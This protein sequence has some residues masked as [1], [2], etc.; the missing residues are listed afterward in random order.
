MP[1]CPVCGGD[2]FST[3]VSSAKL[4]EECRFRERFVRERLNRP[5]NPEELKDL[6]EF[7]H[8]GRAEILACG[9]CGLLVRR[10]HEPPPAQTY[11][12][13]E[14][15]PA[16]MERL[17]PQYLQAFR[18]KE[19]PFRSLLPPGARV[20]EI[21]SHYGAFLQTAQ[22][23]GWSSEGVDVGKD[24][25]RFA[26]SK[27]F[28]VHVAEIHECRFTQAKFDAVFIWNCFDQIDD[29][30]PTLSE[31]YRVI[32][33]G[34]FLILRTPNGVFYKLC[35]NLL[36]DPEL[37]AGSAEFLLEAMGYNNLLGFP[38]LYGYGQATL[39]QLVSPFGFHLEGMLNSEL[40]TLPLPEQ[41]GWVKREERVIN[42]QIRMLAGSVLSDAGALAGPWIEVWFRRE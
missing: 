4:D 20:L 36:S 10:E 40:L 41:P 17:Y 11:S 28:I 31:C 16:L 30:K 14:Y 37:P 12:E 8:Q 5:A 23:W 9:N 24:T 19:K 32:R 6:T 27:G 21:G 3:L 26:Q 13:D 1:E 25:S 7:F 2:C 39:N 33:P 22:E 15:D 18:A 29:A 35:R 34:G 42:S 38:Y